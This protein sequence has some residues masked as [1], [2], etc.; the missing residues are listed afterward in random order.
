[1]EAEGENNWIKVDFISINQVPTNG[2]QGSPTINK[3]NDK[4]IRKLFK[5]CNYETSPHALHKK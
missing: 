2:M 3:T 1:M 4:I 5:N